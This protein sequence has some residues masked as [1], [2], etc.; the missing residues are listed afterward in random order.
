M[1]GWRRH[2]HMMSSCRYAY[3]AS[4]FSTSLA[5]RLRNTHPLDIVGLISVQPQSFHGHPT[6]IQNGAPD[7]RERGLRDWSR[8]IPEHS[9]R[10]LTRSRYQTSLS[11]EAPQA[12]N[13]LSVRYVRRM[14]HEDNLEGKIVSASASTH[15]MSATYVRKPVNAGLREVRS[16]SFIQVA[17]DGV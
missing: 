11:A 7:V 16:P 14:G 13:T 2:R 17:Q 6:S 9:Y 5:A 15:E 12:T 3:D 10:Y 4:A 1:F 8:R